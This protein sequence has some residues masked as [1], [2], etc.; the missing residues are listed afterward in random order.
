M[1]GPFS[2]IPYPYPHISRFGVIPIG[3]KAGKWHLN[4]DLSSPEGHSV[5]DS[6]PK[7]PY[8]VQYITVD[9]LADCHDCHCLKGGTV[10]LGV[11][12]WA[13]FLCDNEAVL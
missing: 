11:T 7:L 2:Y 3:N 13:E 12:T 10:A 1:A 5:D 4:L 8:S 6:I 9:C